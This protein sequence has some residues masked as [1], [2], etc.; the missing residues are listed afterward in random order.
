MVYCINANNNKDNEFHIFPISHYFSLLLYGQ[1]SDGSWP[2]YIPLY[3][4]S[5]KITF[6]DAMANIYENHSTRVCSNVRSSIE[7]CS[8]LVITLQY[9]LKRIFINF[10][11]DM[12]LVQ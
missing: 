1:R 12:L 8:V 10:N 9:V 5:A 3:Q 11:V 4:N 7:A 2:S 6:L